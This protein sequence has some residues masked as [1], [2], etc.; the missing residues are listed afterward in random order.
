MLGQNTVAKHAGTKTCGGSN[1]EKSVLQVPEGYG[2]GT[3]GLVMEENKARTAF[4]QS[5][6]MLYDRNLDKSSFCQ[7]Q[8]MWRRDECLS[9]KERK[10]KPNSH[11]SIYSDEVMYINCI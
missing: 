1:C 7:R 8:Q 6:S 2:V 10:R 5:G 11:L 3:S 9:E 4:C